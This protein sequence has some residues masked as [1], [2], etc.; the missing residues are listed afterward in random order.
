MLLADMEIE[1]DDDA[2]LSVVH[3]ATDRIAR[4]LAQPIPLHGATL[5]IRASIGSAVFPFGAG[6]ARTLLRLADEAMYERKRERSNV[7]TTIRRL[8]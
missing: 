2:V 5:S 7:P 3:D 4:S 6:D 8:A 1:T